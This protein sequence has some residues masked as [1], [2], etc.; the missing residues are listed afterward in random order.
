MITE[1]EK[2]SDSAFEQAL[3]N[4]SQNFGFLQTNRLYEAKLIKKI[5]H[6]AFFDLGRFGTGIVYGVEF[7]N[8]KDIIKNLK[9][10]DKISVK[11]L[12]NETDE[13]YAELSLTQADRM[14][15]WQEIKEMQENGESIKVKIVD[16][17]KGGLIV[18]LDK[19]RAFLPIS[20]LSGENYQKM[21]ENISQEDWQKL[22]ENLKSLIGK[23][24]N[25]KEKCLMKIQK[26]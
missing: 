8:A 23:E 10:G 22:T 7:Q 4:Q 5:R 1:E 18:S 20:Q 17:N 24:L 9:P 14:K 11:F 16:A 6:Q 26:N 19:I 25:V 21:S 3:K 13:G 2:N 15:I 12:G